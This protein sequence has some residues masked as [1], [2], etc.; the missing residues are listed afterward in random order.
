MLKADH[1]EACREFIYSLDAER[2]SDHG[3][4]M[5][6]DRF[7]RREG[8]YRDRSIFWREPHCV[9]HGNY[10][11]PPIKSDTFI[12]CPLGG[13]VDFVRCSFCLLVV[14]GEVR[15]ERCRTMTELR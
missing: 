10:K 7:P 6:P 9:L 2:V 14:I 8:N 15:A 3:H 13:A 1:V 12:G 4:R 5:R 11:Y